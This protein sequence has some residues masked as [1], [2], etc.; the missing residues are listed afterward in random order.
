MKKL[1]ISMFL[2]T[3]WT[4]IITA[5]DPTKDGI[6]YI[7]NEN[8]GEATKIFENLAKDPKNAT[9]HYY[10]GKIRYILEDYKG[11]EAAYNKGL[12]VSNKCLGKYPSAL[13]MT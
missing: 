1:I 2:M 9:A 5:Q 8:Y 7:A 4:S 13:I 3:I 12:L 11:A 6:K 10:L